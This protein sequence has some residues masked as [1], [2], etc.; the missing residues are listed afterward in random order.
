MTRKTAFQT[1]H[2]IVVAAKLEYVHILRP[3]SAMVVNRVEN[4]G[5]CIWDQTGR[6]RVHPEW[7][8]SQGRGWKFETQA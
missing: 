5:L 4:D 2:L 6:P 3:I 7:S 8:P 1:V